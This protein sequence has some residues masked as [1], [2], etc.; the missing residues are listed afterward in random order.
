M[1]DYFGG[2]HSPVAPLAKPCWHSHLSPVL[3][4]CVFVVIFATNEPLVIV[5]D[6]HKHLSKRQTQLTFH[7]DC[8]I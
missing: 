3:F 7:I 2:S 5:I 8:H 6:E 4:V 1:P